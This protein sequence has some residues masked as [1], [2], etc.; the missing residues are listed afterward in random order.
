METEAMRSLLDRIP[1]IRTVC[2]LDVLLFFHRHPRSL[3]TSE[4]LLAYLGYDREQVA[5]SLDGLIE[6]GLLSRS[7]NP[8]HTARLYVLEVRGPSGGSL[9]SLMKFASTYEGRQG[10]MRLLRPKADRGP[11]REDPSGQHLIRVA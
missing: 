10:V 2:D 7:Q 1:G 5:K 9:E 4:Q 3:L 8:S 6:A 11:R